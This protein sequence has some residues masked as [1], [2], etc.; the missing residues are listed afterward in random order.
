MAKNN[1]NSIFFKKKFPEWKSSDSDI[2]QCQAKGFMPPGCSLWRS[3]FRGS[4]C[5]WLRVVGTV[6]ADPDLAVPAPVWD[7]ARPGLGSS[8]TRGWL[9]FLV[10]PWLSSKYV[11]VFPF[12]VDVCDRR[13]CV[14]ALAPVLASG[15][16]GTCRRTAA[17]RCP[18]LSMGEIA[19]PHAGR[20][21]RT[22]GNAT[23]PCT[24]CQRRPAPSV[25]FFEYAGGPTRQGVA[26]ASSAPRLTGGAQLLGASL[27]ENIDLPRSSLHELDQLL[28]FG[29]PW[30][31]SRGDKGCQARF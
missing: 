11:C 27:P 20:L 16:I 28:L 9:F 30:N 15:G 7:R 4:S 19:K 31:S 8:V 3:N 5:T 2:L 14:R 21:C 6:P 29:G 22:R 10:F 23:C 1:P 26:R 25:A 12:G 24:P 13:E 18:G 17:S